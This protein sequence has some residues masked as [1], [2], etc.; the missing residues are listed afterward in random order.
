MQADVGWI[1]QEL[2]EVRGD[3]RVLKEERDQARADYT[4]AQAQLEAA[5]QEIGRL[6]QDLE[7]TG[8][9]RDE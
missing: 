8:T 4:Q 2:N 7:N 9:E 1:E 3:C 6:K 5:Q